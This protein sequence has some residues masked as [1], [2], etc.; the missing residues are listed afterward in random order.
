VVGFYSFFATEPRGRYR[1]LFSD[2]ITDEMAGSDALRQRMLDAF[3]RA[4]RG[5]PRRAGVDRSHQLHRALRSGAGAAGQRSRDRAADAARIGAICSLIRGGVPLDQWP[6]NLFAIHSHV[7]RR[8]RLLHAAGAG[9]GHRRGHR[10]R[11][12]GDDRRGR[13]RGPARSRRR[14]LPDR[15]QKWAACAAAPG[16]TRYVVC[17]ADE[18]EPGTFKDR[19]LLMNHAELVIEGMTVAALRGGRAAQ[20]SSTCAPSTR[21]WSRRSARRW[22]A[23][24]AGLLGR[25]SAAAPA[26][27]STSSCTSAPART[28][29]AR[30]RR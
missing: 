8:D 5:Q 22:P 11:R 29:A 21:S 15:R 1:V 19:E 25:A 13:A 24:A 20:G 6:D 16:P 28:C 23:R 3:H 4:R 2:N 14:R 7:E 10:P 30:S 9:R 17:N 12:G 18:G 26:S 27:T